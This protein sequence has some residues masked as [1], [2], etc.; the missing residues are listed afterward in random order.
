MG[1]VTFIGRKTA[2]FEYEI[3]DEH[4]E[5]RTSMQIL[6]FWCCMQFGTLWDMFKI[7]LAVFFLLTRRNLQLCLK[8][9]FWIFQKFRVFALYA[10]WHTLGHIWNAVWN[11]YLFITIRKRLWLA[12][13]FICFD[14]FWVFDVACN[15]GHFGTCLKFN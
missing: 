13:M 5:Q 11:A 1:F 4:L 3:I 7:Q 12:K 15:L 9:I 10:D 14:K 2:Y 6:S 8:Y